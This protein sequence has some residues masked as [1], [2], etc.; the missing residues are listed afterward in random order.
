MSACAPSTA[1]SRW[2]ITAA[3]RASACRDFVWAYLDGGAE[4][5]VTLRENRTGFSAWSLRAHMLTG[6]GK[7][8]LTTM[9]WAR[10][11]AC[12]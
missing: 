8:D 10:R 5:L 2:R 7:P 4:D 3:P 1:T 6:H 9:R 11:C 12:P